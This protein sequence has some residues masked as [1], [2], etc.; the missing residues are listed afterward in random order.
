MKSILRRSLFTGTALVLSALLLAGCAT[1]ID[2]NT[3]VG[4]YTYDQAVLELGPPDKHAQ[5]SDGTTV[6]EWLAYRGGTSRVFA[7]GGYAH[8]HR[9][10]VH[11]GP[12][13]YLDDYTT[14]ENFL[15]LVF[16]PDGVLKS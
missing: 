11:G 14:Y 6:A 1:A 16:A 10:Y 9:G 13:F 8:W 12:A 2:W 4:T 3:R 5:L 15:R 7:T